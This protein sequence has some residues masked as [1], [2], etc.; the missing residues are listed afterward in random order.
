[1]YSNLKNQA[2]FVGIRK[3]ASSSIGQALYFYQHG[4]YYEKDINESNIYK[5]SHSVPEDLNKFK[6]TCIRDPYLRLI[7]GFNHKVLE[8]PSQEI[9]GY[10]IYNPEHRSLISD[11]YAYFDNFLSYLENT[12]L[13]N[14]DYHFKSQHDLAMFDYI[15]YDYILRFENL[16]KDWS[17]VQEKIAGMPNIEHHIHQSYSEIYAE[18]LRDKFFDR[19]NSLYYNDRINYLNSI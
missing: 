5:Y 14:I 7:S 3:N 6:F 12:G 17:V 10:D 11:T 13:N 2:S 16:S 18:M 8:H 15:D 9:E 19:V 4:E 1:M